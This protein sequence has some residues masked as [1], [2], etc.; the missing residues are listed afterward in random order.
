MTL[1]NDK[2]KK[3][4][5]RELFEEDS[6]SWT[7]IPLFTRDAPDV[8]LKKADKAEWER[9]YKGIAWGYRLKYQ[10]HCPTHPLSWYIE[11]IKSCIRAFQ[12][13][14]WP[15]IPFR[16]AMTAIK[17]MRRF[18]RLCAQRRIQTVHEANEHLLGAV[19]EASAIK[20][21]NATLASTP[22]TAAQAPTMDQLRDQCMSVVRQYHSKRR[23][24]FA[25][26]FHTWFG[27]VWG[28]Q[29]N[30]REDTKQ[31]LFLVYDHWRV[32]ASP[33]D[34]SSLDE[35]LNRT[36]ERLR[37][38]GRLQPQFT[39]PLGRQA[40]MKLVQQVE[41]TQDSSQPT[42]AKTGSADK[43][44]PKVLSTPPEAAPAPQPQSEP[45]ATVSSDNEKPPSFLP[46]IAANKGAPP[47]D[48]MDLMIKKSKLTKL[49]KEPSK[50]VPTPVSSLLV[51]QPANL[52]NS[53]RHTVPG[54]GRN[55]VQLPSLTQGQVQ[56]QRHDKLSSV[57]TQPVPRP[58]LSSTRPTA[59]QSLEGNNA[60]SHSVSPDLTLK[61]TETPLY[62]LCRTRLKRMR[63]KPSRQDMVLVPEKS[64]PSSKIPVEEDPGDI[65]EQQVEPTPVD[66][67][68]Q[69]VAEEVPVEDSLS[70]KE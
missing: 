2:N 70:S 11:C 38:V 41:A 50:F 23:R 3:R 7:R 26:R 17:H 22:T 45:P 61:Y 27:E 28:F 48:S 14:R 19:V 39:M 63:T 1:H 21:S 64:K 16:T 66:E 31:R 57:V 10:V 49:T 8:A 54:P 40:L 67:P 44:T 29:K 24:Q 13:K 33:P 43:P 36:Q 42:H 62:K 68:S 53:Q 5:H 69:S 18:G 15:A 32:G 55:G 34:T 56:V 4:T 6:P 20:K 65:P 46:A 37:A 60:R 58:F 9:F 30:Y 59:L 47:P 52:S 25:K 51:R 35:R 12:P